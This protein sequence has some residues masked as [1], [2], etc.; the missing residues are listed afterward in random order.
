MREEV[1]REYSRSYKRNSFCHHGCSW[2]WNII[3]PE[4]VKGRFS[5]A[6]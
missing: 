5:A 3:H 2:K 1:Q 6:V 4:R